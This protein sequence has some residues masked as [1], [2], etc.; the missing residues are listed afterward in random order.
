LALKPVKRFFWIL[1]LPLS[2]MIS[3]AGGLALPDLLE[4]MR[5]GQE[6]LNANYA[7]DADKFK[8]KKVDIQLTQDG[9]F[10]CRRT[11]ISGKQEYYSFSFADLADFD[12]LG[13]TQ[14]GWILL[15]TKPESIIV[16][17]FRDP[18]G[19]IDTMA[20]ELKLPFKN[21]EAADLHQLNACFV[22]IRE[23]LK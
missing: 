17:T 14:N 13:N 8:M 9:F 19:N 10:R 7:L 20:T 6:K 4:L 1:L 2:G 11:F 3:L 12:Y 5:Q 21:L 16:Q 23:R 22:Q 18:K 15:K